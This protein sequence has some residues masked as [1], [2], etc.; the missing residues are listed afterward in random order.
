LQE[1]RA[2]GAPAA[3][4]FK[5]HKSRRRERYP[6]RRGSGHERSVTIIAVSLLTRTWPLALA[7]LLVVAG[8]G[9]P[10]D[11]V[12]TPTVTGTATP[13]PAASMWT[14]P[15]DAP[16]VQACDDIKRV[17]AAD[18]AAGHRPD[19]DAMARIAGLAAQSTDRSIT[20]TGLLLKSAAESA[21]A[22]K[23]T[24]DEPTSLS[25]LSTAALN[26]ETACTTSRY[27]R[28]A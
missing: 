10:A 25:S 7:A 23:G 13:A 1:L 18:L 22:A 20:T 14:L 8:C 12:A 9:K 2:E 28:P 5:I 11:R 27:Y 21:K 3:T 17:N 19:P 16:G 15:A 4:G 24:Q 6:F 26:L